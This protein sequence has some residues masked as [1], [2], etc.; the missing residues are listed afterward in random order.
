MTDNKDDLIY[1]ARAAGYKEG[2]AAGER[3]VMSLG[4]FAVAA[5]IISFIGAILYA[6]VVS[7]RAKADIALSAC[8][9]D[10]T[11]PARAIVCAVAAGRKL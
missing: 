6:E 7:T 3:I 5:A 10:L 11:E 8:A 4:I 1:S 2:A 9:G